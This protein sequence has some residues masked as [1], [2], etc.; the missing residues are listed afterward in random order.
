MNSEELELSLRTEFENYLKNFRAD[1]REQANELRKQ[2]EAEAEKHRSQLNEA[3]EAY[4]ARF[5][6]EH[7]FDEGFKASVVEHLRQARDEGAA[8]TA[9]AMD[10]AQAMENAT[11]APADYKAIR[12]AIDDISQHRSQAAILKSL[13]EHASNFAPR[14]AFFII[15]NEQLV[16]WNVFGADSSADAAVKDI[17]F[18][19]SSNSLLGTAVNSLT[20]ADG[21]FGTHEDN[22]LFL[23]PLHFGQ[24]DR[25]HAIPLVA[26]GR[27]VAVLYA[28]YGASGVNVN[29]EALEA[30]VRIAGLTVELLASSQTAKAENRQ[31]AEANFEDV[32]T[33]EAQP[34]VQAQPVVHEEV[35]H[36]EAPAEVHEPAPV[37]AHETDFSFSES[38][39]AEAVQEVESPFSSP[40]EAEIVSEVEEV[41]SFEPVAEPEQEGE[42]IFDAGE[43][44][45]AEI[46]EPSPFDSTVDFEPAGVGIG[47]LKKGDKAVEVSPANVGRVHAKSER[48]VD[49]PIEVSDEERRPHNDARRFARLLVSEIKLYNE[50]RVTEGRQ[51]GDLYV[52]LREAIDRS[53]EMYDK[54]VQ[55]PVAEKFDYFHYELVNSLADGNADQMGNG[56]PGA[57]V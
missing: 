55:P 42:V 32:R 49:L 38:V 54:R 18:P 16:G 11:P 57:S 24:P 36:V 41:T 33:E 27:G 1:M 43:S 56:Y 21:A 37:E 26:R 25:M 7:A 12:D 2:F 15:K 29:V 9:N 48:N 50:Q 53:R 10:Q 19:I 8:L 44:L 47:V 5:D 22:P 14:G 45:G 40:V 3:F 23:D 39:P 13:V 4:A 35:Q 17:K 51:A 31:V 20:T 28:D 46:H 52:R 6:S 30:I 34:A